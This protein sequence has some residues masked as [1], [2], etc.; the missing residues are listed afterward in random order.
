LLRKQ[1]DALRGE[2]P[3]NEVPGILKYF[4]LYCHFPYGEWWKDARKLKDDFR[5]LE[6]EA[7]NLGAIPNDYDDY[8]L[9]DGA[10]DEQKKQFAYL[11]SRTSLRTY[12]NVTHGEWVRRAQILQFLEQNDPRTN[13]VEPPPKST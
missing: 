8:V 6:A 11:F 4:I 12:Y 9:P 1:L 3:W 2:V 10:S 7:Q 5:K 13:R